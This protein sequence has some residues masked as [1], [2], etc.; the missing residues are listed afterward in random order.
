MPAPP[1]GL[2]A[3]A[4]VDRVVDG[5]TVDVRVVIPVR[6]R[7][8]D[9]WAPE[10]T[11]IDKIAGNESKIAL[12]RM[13]PNGTPVHVNIPTRDVDAMGGVL[14]FGRVLGH[15]YAIGEDESVSEKMVSAGFAQ[16]A[17]VKP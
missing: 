11:G 15:I 13:L 17:K 10:I 1:L 5:D 7:L 8:L 12:E 4:I 9:C 16:E 14:T 2:T 3:R 6:V